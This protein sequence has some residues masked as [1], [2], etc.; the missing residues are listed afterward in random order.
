MFGSFGLQELLVILLIVVILFGASRL[1]Q[2]GKSLGQGFRNFRDA[3][4][5]EEPPS[6]E[7]PADK[8]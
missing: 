1:P 2:L 8:S 4:K 5:R 6:D 7:S 3:F